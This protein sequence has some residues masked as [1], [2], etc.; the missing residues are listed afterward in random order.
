MG[1]GPPDGRSPD[2]SV[3]VLAGPD[4]LVAVLAF[5]FGERCVDRGREA[6]VVQLDREVVAVALVGALLPGRTEFNI[7]RCTA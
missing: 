6:W 5:D 2:V 7:M 1:E 3:A 4:Q